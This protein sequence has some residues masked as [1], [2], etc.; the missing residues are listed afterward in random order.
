MRSLIICNKILRWMLIRLKH[1]IFTIWTWCKKT[2]TWDLS[3]A[4]KRTSKPRSTS[5]S[6]RISSSWKKRGSKCRWWGGFRINKTI[7]EFKMIIK[8]NNSKWCRSSNNNRI[9]SIMETSRISMGKSNMYRRMVKIS[10]IS[11]KIFREDCSSH[12]KKMI[13]FSRIK[14][15]RFSRGTKTITIRGSSGET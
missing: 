12:G 4:K 7:L 14:L 8:S 2:T 9:N 11:N 10:R 15:T 3:T 5:K 1:L 6:H 13:R